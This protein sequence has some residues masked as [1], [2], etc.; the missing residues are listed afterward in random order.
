MYTWRPCPVVEVQDDVEAA[1]DWA[2]H[3]TKKN[4]GKVSSAMRVPPLMPAVITVNRKDGVK[5]LIDIYRR[6]D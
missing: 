6:R 2:L 3:D 1:T 5:A 4:R